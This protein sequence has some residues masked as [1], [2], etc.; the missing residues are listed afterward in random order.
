MHRRCLSRF[1]CRGLSP[2]L[3]LVVRMPTARGLLALFMLPGLC[4]TARWLG[5]WEVCANMLALPDWLWGRPGW[6]P[7]HSRCAQHPE[8][9]A[10]VLLEMPWNKNTS[11]T[12]HGLGSSKGQALRH[13]FRN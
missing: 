2:L 8:Y 7:A 5:P 12:L 11:H 9:L 1:T 6:G 13:K 3:K 4:C 10:R